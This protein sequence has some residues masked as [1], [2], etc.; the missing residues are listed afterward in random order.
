MTDGPIAIAGIVIP[1]ND[2]KFLAIVAVHIL[3][4]VVCVVA[5]ASAMLSRKARGNHTRAG[6][7][8]YRSLV[9]VFATMSALAAMRWA[10]DYHLF[11]LGFLS[12]S[13]A[14]VARRFVNHRSLWRIRGHIMAMGVSYVLLLVAFYVD[15][16][17][18]LP[19]WRN[20]PPITYWALPV[21][22]GGGLI[23]RT[24]A[25]HPLAV[26]ERKPARDPI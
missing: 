17:R 14:V 16:G 6:L 20:L 26:A 10:D 1:T 22:L 13:A 2:P 24:I 19:L 4:G 12:L 8:Y 3:A 25:R 15:N 5:G 7:L 18:N 23:V 21:L 11:V 9:I